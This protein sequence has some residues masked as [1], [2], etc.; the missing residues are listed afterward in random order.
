VPIAVT[1]AGVGLNARLKVDRWLSVGLGRAGPTGPVADSDVLLTDHAL[2]TYRSGWAR[3][4]A[5]TRT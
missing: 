4:I 3:T 5:R 2:D 1:P